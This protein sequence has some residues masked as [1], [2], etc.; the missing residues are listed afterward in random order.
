MDLEKLKQIKAE[1]EDENSFISVKFNRIVNEFTKRDHFCVLY[2]DII[3]RCKDFNFQTTAATVRIPYKDPS[4]GFLIDGAISSSVGIYQRAPGVLRSKDKDSDGRYQ[5]DIVSSRNTVVTML[6]KRGGIVISFKR[7]TKSNAVPVGVFLKAIAGLPYR[8]LLDLI[9]FKSVELLNS[10]PAE[11]GGSNT[12]LT[13]SKAFG[14]KGAMQEPSHEEC[15]DA[16][17]NAIY[18]INPNATDSAGRPLK[19]YTYSTQWKLSRIRAYLNNL[20][21]KN[22]RLKSMELG[23]RAVGCTTARAVSIPI[24]S[25]EGQATVKS[26]SRDVYI[27][28]QMGQELNKYDLESLFVRVEH[29]P[30]AIQSKCSMW[31]RAKGYKLARDY[32]ELGLKAGWIIGDEELKLLNATDMR[33]IQV[34]TPEGAKTIRRSGEQPELSDFINIINCLMTTDF[35]KIDDTEAYNVS[36]RIIVDYDRRVRNEVEAVYDSIIESLGNG[37]TM[38]N[39]L[40]LPKL[41]SDALKGLVTDRENKEIC[42]SDM[43][44]IMSRAISDSKASAQMLSTPVSMQAVQPDQYGRL[45]SLHAPESDKI[46]AVQQLTVL[47]ALREDTGEITTPLEIIKD[48][49]PTGK[50]DYVTASKEAN[51]YVAAW[52]DELSS[53]EIKVRFNGDL[54][55]VDVTQVNYRDVSPFQ[56]MSISRATV[57][58]P[59]FSMPRRSLMATKMSGQAVPLLFPERP[60]VGTGAET[61][62]PCTYYSVEDILRTSGVELKPGGILKVL[63]VKWSPMKAEYTMVYESS[64]FSFSVP[65]VATDKETLYCFRINHTPEHVYR[66]DDI[67]FYNQSCDLKEHEYWTREKQGTVPFIKDVARPSMALGTNLRVC[68]KTSGSSTIDDAVCISSR[69]VTDMTLSS[70]QIFK[71]DYDLKGSEKSEDLVLAKLHQ[72]VS[73]GTPVIWLNREGKRPKLV[74]A[75]LDGDVIKAEVTSKG[76]SVW[77]ASYHDAEVG[78]KVAGR[79][80]N[81]SVIARICPEGQ[82]PYDP[83][84]GEIMDICCSPLGIPSRM[85]LGQLLEVALGGVMLRRNQYAVVTPFYKGIKQDIEREL[86]L[87]DMKPKRLF[88]PEYGRLSERPVT[89]GVMYFLKLEQIANLKLAAVGY[90]TAV[91]PVFGQ[92]SSSASGAKGQAMGEMELWALIAAGAKDTL[93]AFCTIYSESEAVRKKYFEM[94]QGSMTVS[95]QKWD[96]SEA[97]LNTYQVNNRGAMVVQTVYRMFGLDVTLKDSDPE[98]FFFR[99][100]DMDDITITTSVRNLQDHTE[101]IEDNEWSKIKLK[102]ETINPF[103]VQTFP[104]G[105]LLGVKSLQSLAS[106]KMLYSTYTGEVIRPKDIGARNP[107][108][109]ITGI[110]AVLTLIKETTLD[111]CYENLKKAAVSSGVEDQDA[112]DLASQAQEDKNVV[113]AGK[114]L[115]LDDNDSDRPIDLYESPSAEYA[116]LTRFLNMLRAAGKELDSLIWKEM[117]VLPK[118]FRQST[119]SRERERDIRHPFQTQ[120]EN[121]CMQADPQSAYDALCQYIGFGRQKNK[122]F[123]SIRQYFFGK[124]AGEDDHG[125]VRSAVLA[126]TIGFSGR[127]VI[128]PAQDITMPPYF[129]G[130][131]WKIA[132]TELAKP[133]AIKLQYKMNEFQ[134]L[135]RANQI[136]MAVEVMYTISVDSLASLIETLWEY[137]PKAIMEIVPVDESSVADFY[138]V[139]RDYIKGLCEGGVREDGAVRHDGEW[140]YPEDLEKGDTI[141]AAVVEAGRQPTLHKKSIRI[142]FM[143]LVD[144]YAMQLHPT[145]CNAYNADFDGDTMH[146]AA[147]LGDTKV[148]GWKTLSV[149][150]D[151]ISEKDG[152]YTLK[153]LQDSALG[154]YCATTFKNS[155]EKPSY[156]LGEFYCFDSQEDLL[157]QLQYGTLNYYDPVLFTSSAK[158]KYLSTAGRIAAN[159]ALVDGLTSMPA[160]DPDGI[161]AQ[162]LGNVPLKGLCSLRYDMPWVATDLRPAGRNRGA[163]LE[164]ILLETYKTFGARKSIDVT[165][166]LY[167]LGVVASDIYSVSMGIEDMGIDVDVNAF[168]EEPRSNANK[169]NSLYQLGLISDEERKLASASAWEGAKSKTKSAVIAA[170]SPQSNMFYSLYS[171]ARGKTD[172]L[173]QAVGFIGS[174]SKTASTDIEYPIL[175]GY[176]SGLSSL[177][178][179]QTGYSARIGVVSTQ[180]GTKMTGYATRQSV[181]MNSG[182]CITSDCNISIKTEP[183]RYDEEY[184][185]LA[186][187]GEGLVSAEDIVGRFVD[188]NDPRNQ[189]LM[190]RYRVELNK[191]GFILKEEILEDAIQTGVMEIAFLDHKLLT[192]KKRLEPNFRNEML[193]M[194]SFALP[195]TENMRITERT[196]DWVEDYELT[197]IV[198]FTQEELDS[199]SCYDSAYLEVE[200]NKSKYVCMLDG[201]EIAVEALYHCKVSEESEGFHYYQRLLGEG[202]TMTTK[203]LQYLTKKG[204]HTLVLADGRT[205]E[206]RYSLTPLFKN[207]AA[208]R[209]ACG[210]PYLGSDNEITPKTLEVIEKY[211]LSHIGVFTSLTCLSTTGVCKT[212]YGKS[213]TTNGFTEEGT[214]VAIPADQAMCEPLSQAT[215]NVTHSG[216]N[217]AGGTG[218]VSGLSYY[219]KLLK[220]SVV[221]QKNQDELEVFAPVSGYVY[222]EQEGEVQVVRIVDANNL[223]LFEKGLSGIQYCSLPN[224]AYVEKG[225]TVISG[226][227]NLNRYASTNVARAALKTRYLLIQEYQKV[228]EKLSV[229]PRNFEIMARAQTSNCFLVANVDEEGVKDTAIESMEKTGHYELRVSTQARTV[230]RFSG[231]ASFGF[232]NAPQMMLSNLIDGSVGNNS[233]LSNIITGT[234]IGSTEAK[235][236]PV[237]HGVATSSHRKSAVSRQEDLIYRDFGTK[238]MLSL[239]GMKEDRQLLEA[240]VIRED[241]A[242]VVQRLSLEAREK[243][244]KKALAASNESDDNPFALEPKLTTLALPD[245]VEKES[246]F[247]AL[248]SI[249]NMQ[250]VDVPWEEAEPEELPREEINKLK[251]D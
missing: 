53:K 195:F 105:K 208:G 240:A 127:C 235:M 165:H 217:R 219:M 13:R 147:C 139:L 178:L 28:A 221:S 124:G 212:C 14:A 175:S 21:F 9:T 8:V 250:P 108:E 227:V 186:L 78:D 94:L 191:S 143:R 126:K 97:Q 249:G 52:D 81:K 136:R 79:Y 98:R 35:Q 29:K 222:V 114:V 163:K 46:G 246:P 93:N 100:L 155:A 202:N 190:E 61:E 179:Y 160:T 194:Y 7:G 6:Y 133:L 48:G 72:F 166:R 88:L 151:L 207:L 63:G 205:I 134:N 220:G 43:T 71:Y 19:Q 107:N 154:L 70:I 120:I 1:I 36:N 113:F 17:Y 51:R 22:S 116:G 135:L 244:A 211:Q 156:A 167:Q 140:V 125:K 182:L 95:G 3:Y 89:T 55:T 38:D 138:N 84:T 152:S 30:F 49:I 137:N 4:M 57:P 224:G 15:V 42:Q 198:A 153:L 27:D 184:V 243:E 162:V 142:Y 64:R 54:T 164:D 123:T 197:D 132:M 231:L 104:L 216:G 237:R 41:P 192:V 92:P 145:V 106:G 115:N 34:L 58:F 65:F 20:G 18:N 150:Q 99:P 12:S 102:T 168:M 199:G 161:C 149:L 121:I 169:L 62:V 200:Y 174:I 229:S 172:Q 242:S 239:N 189:D 96:E 248:P 238:A 31:F 87:E 171:G 24:F 44:N 50:I 112:T 213:L 90:P 119:M 141:E 210:L 233:W 77:V 181:Y 236:I 204:L 128:I 33:S 67:V 214:N 183:V 80:G 185:S 158:R 180:D 118:V 122:N 218:L 228:F 241:A 66:N 91:D 117:P 251:F 5:I 26:Y 129:I 144:G 39:K 109:F 131:P 170:L 40:Q 232:E 32:S 47:A 83:E 68:Y 103:W 226:Y 110:K 101:G 215:L 37:L 234:P 196:L 209:V 82:M 148:E 111:Q 69:L 247:T 76:A 206:L 188:P 177:D 203:A 86:E 176:G 56:D 157:E 60:R 130:V 2:S 73:T 75:K 16:V 59:E 11:L 193:S 187:E 225:D 201:K 159:L 45:D 146:V 245:Q 85:N 173:M 74:K 25:D 223:P 230:Q 23:N 10:F